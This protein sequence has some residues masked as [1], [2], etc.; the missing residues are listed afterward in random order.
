MDNTTI[1][2]V[3]E[4]RYARIAEAVRRLQEEYS[5]ACVEVMNYGGIELRKG[6]IIEIMLKGRTIKDVMVAEFEC[7][8]PYYATIKVNTN[9]YEVV[10]KLRDIK[11]IRRRRVK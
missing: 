5:S 2:K 7:I 9:E 8:N 1:T 4:E 10:I 6:D 3:K 11:F